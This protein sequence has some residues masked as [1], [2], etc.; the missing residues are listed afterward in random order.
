MSTYDSKGLLITEA[1]KQIQECIDTKRSFAVVAGA[2]SGKT[3]SLVSALDYIRKKDSR[4]L[5]RDGKQ[6][7]CITFTNRAIDVISNRLG[8]DDLYRVCT[9]HSFLW[10]EISRFAK[11]IKQSLISNRI[12]LLIEEQK[13]KDN[14]G[15]S[16]KAIA[17]RHKMSALSEDIKSLD[18]IQNFTYDDTSIFSTYSEGKLSHDDV[19]AIAADLIKEKEILRKIIGQKYPFI[20]VDEAQD[21]FDVIVDALNLICVEDGLSVVGYFGDPMQQIYDK[22]AGDFHA[23]KGIQLIT[24]EENFRCSPEVIELL[25]NFRTD[26]KQYAAGKNSDQKGSVEVILIESETPEAPRNKYSDQQLDQVAEKFDSLVELWGWNNQSNVKLLFLVRQMIAR[27]LGFIELHKL[28]TGEYASSNA[29]EKY[30]SGEHFLLKPFVNLICPLVKSIQQKDEHTLIKLLREQSPAFN[31][32]SEDTE[33]PLKEMLQLARELVDGLM[34][35]W[36]KSNLKDI[37][38]YV[39]ESCLFNFSERLIEEIMRSPRSDEYDKDRHSREKGE[40]L[41]DIFFTM[42]TSEILKYFDFISD[43]T[44]FSTQHGVKGE[45]YKNVVVLFDDVEAS[46]HNYSFTRT[47]TPATSGDGKE[48]QIERTRRL[49]YVCFSRAEVNLKIIF[50]TPSPSDAKEE[51]IRNGAFKEEQVLLSRL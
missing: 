51:L 15:K 13:K 16:K 38:S 23:F 8:W 41:A 6:I 47:L 45:E 18:N 36:D 24:K 10:A 27:R 20:F 30:E 21:T 40:W 42:D 34:E 37:L 33:R 28:F 50:F 22:R 32:L 46:W 9:L 1:D 31:T 19:V 3:T 43:N 7:A 4:K 17:A 29:K 12:P 26:V 25:N 5:R 48:S 44:P 35:H 11:E 14:G 39:E 2:G 49:A